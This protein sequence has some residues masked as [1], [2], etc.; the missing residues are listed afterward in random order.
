MSAAPNSSVANTF[1]TTKGVIFMTAKPVY[2]PIE[3]VSTLA[4]VIHD[5]KQA[6]GKDVERFQPGIVSC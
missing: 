3:S 4:S 6:Y 5:I 2:N 1:Y